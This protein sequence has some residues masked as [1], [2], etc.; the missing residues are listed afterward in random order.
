M[1][2]RRSWVGPAAPDRPAPP[3]PG[4]RTSPGAAP[5]PRDGRPRNR[6]VGRPVE[7]PVTTRWRQAPILTPVVLLVPLVAGRF[8]AWTAAAGARTPSGQ[9]PN[10]LTAQ[11]T[12]TGLLS[13]PMAS[14]MWSAVAVTRSFAACHRAGSPSSPA[15]GAGDSLAAGGQPSMPT[16]GWRPIP[17]SPSPAMARCASP[18]PGMVAYERCSGTASSKPSAV[19]A[20]FPCRPSTAR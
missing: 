3:A 1:T 19:V 20:T 10:R 16:S 12:R 4:V 8:G 11:N 17:A 18:T 14:C 15:A 5:D 9:V 13:P 6:L 2:A 7:L